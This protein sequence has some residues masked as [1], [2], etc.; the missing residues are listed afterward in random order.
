MLGSWPEKLWKARK[1]SSEVYEEYL[2]SCRDGVVAR[3][4]NFDEVVAREDEVKLAQ[5]SACSLLLPLDHLCSQ[6]D[7]TLPLSDKGDSGKHVACRGWS[8]IA[9]WCLSPLRCSLLQEIA[10]NVKR[11]RENTA[12]FQ[13]FPEVPAATEWSADVQKLVFV[14]GVPLQ[15]HML[16]S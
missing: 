5:D 15:A 1:L 14:P 11:L 16:R 7:R 12:L 2:Y 13:P 4:R 8:W 9:R 3:K 6:A 10:G